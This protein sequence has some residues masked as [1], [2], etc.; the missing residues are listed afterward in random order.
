MILCVMVTY[1]TKH[2]KYIIPITVIDQKSHNIEKIIEYS[3][4]DDII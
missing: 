4:I 3:E 1:V 2:D